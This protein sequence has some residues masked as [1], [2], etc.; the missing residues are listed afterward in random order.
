MSIQRIVNLNSI[1]AKNRFDFDYLISKNEN[2][3]DT[4]CK[5][6]NNSII[7]IFTPNTNIKTN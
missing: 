5:V 4:K 7:F 6:D 2:L 3:V 1:N